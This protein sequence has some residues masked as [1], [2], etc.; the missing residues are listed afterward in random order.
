M[1]VDLADAALLFH[2]GVSQDDIAEILDLTADWVTEAR[3]RIDTWLIT[4]DSPL[5]SIRARLAA[6]EDVL[7]KLSGMMAECV[8]LLARGMTP[9]EISEHIGTSVKTVHSNL[10]YANAALNRIVG[11]DYPAQIF[12]KTLRKV[13]AR[14]ADRA[15]AVAITDVLR[16][17]GVP[18][19][20]PPEYVEAAID[21]ALRERAALLALRRR[22]DR[23]LASMLDETSSAAAYRALASLDRR[24][25]RL[26][27]EYARGQNRPGRH[28]DDVE[29]ALGLFADALRRAAEDERDERDPMSARSVLPSPESTGAEPGHSA[30]STDP[31]NEE[32]RG[33]EPGPVADDLSTFREPLHPRAIPPIPEGPIDLNEFDPEEPFA[34][35]DVLELLRRR[36]RKQ[37]HNF[38]DGYGIRQIRR[39]EHHDQQASA[40]MAIAVCITNSLPD[41]FAVAL[42]HWF[43]GGRGVGR[44]DPG[45]EFAPRAADVDPKMPYPAN[46]WL[47]LLRRYLGIEQNDFAIGVG[48]RQLR[49]IETDTVEARPEIVQ[50]ACRNYGI[51]TDTAQ[52]VLLLLGA[53]DASVVS[54]SISTRS[55]AAGR[56]DQQGFIDESRSR[57]AEHFT[58]PAH[59]ENLE[60]RRFQARG[61]D[62]DHT[63]VPPP[64]QPPVLPDESRWRSDPFLLDLN[65]PIEFDLEEP[66]SHGRH[67]LT[68]TPGVV[69]EQAAEF[70]AGAYCHFLAGAL[71]SLTSWDVV[72]IDAMADGQWVPRHV[73]VRTP[74]GDL[75]DILGRA[76]LAELMSGVKGETLRH[77][78]VTGEHRPDE[79]VT[80]ADFLRD[81]YLRGNDLWWVAEQPIEFVAALSHFAV[82]V[83]L[84]NG[85]ADFVDPISGHPLGTTFSGVTQE[86]VTLVRDIAAASDRREDMVDGP[87]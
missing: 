63:A 9:V 2:A 27:T 55:A 79:V 76:D 14:R 7:W 62:S 71:H 50:N 78:V 42:L 22:A 24:E 58:P 75:L 46:D 29:R 56:V 3:E 21:S 23:P 52:E 15:L 81:N 82:Q 37:Q 32:A 36:L 65:G 31:V 77:R 11:P 45:R 17:R 25:R 51:S 4:A 67:K 33:L 39:V 26:V 87:S 66:T 83:L 49:R 86:P 69:D 16:G 18:A 47:R 54:R 68:L 80:E 34:L 20:A 28:S 38:A 72:V 1:P 74:D 30:A 6:D 40:E 84:H 13:T 10:R 43:C 41:D 12:E 19:F 59:P 53:P 64:P 5:S 44:F 70:F 85:Y 35:N 57:V 61:A 73:A 60:W 8:E 48:V